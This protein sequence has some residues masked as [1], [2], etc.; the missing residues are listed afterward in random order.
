MGLFDSVMV[1]CPKCGVGQEA[2]SK[3]G[4]CLLGFFPLESAPA[5]VMEDVNRHAP[6]TCSACGTKF[7]VETVQRFTESLD[8][9]Y[10]T[11][12]VGTPPQP[13]RPPFSITGP[14]DR[15]LYFIDTEFDEDGKTINLLSIGITDDQ[16]R[17]FY[18]VSGEANHKRCN[19]W[20]K[21]NVLPHLG[22]S[23]PSPYLPDAP[24]HTREEIAAGI[25]KMLEDRFALDRKLPLFYGYFADYDWVVLCQLYGRMVDLPNLFGHFCM[26][27]K[28]IAVMMGVQKSEYPKQGTIEHNALNDA[29]WNWELFKFLKGFGA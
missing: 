15:A 25:I 7:K 1:P 12:P 8:G 2:Q 18:A 10:R 24:V 29:K 16:G 5:D 13:K 23:L 26:D 21:K 20:V 3:S 6:F 9:K 28:Q 19:D 17:D 27:L 14:K 11:E 4:P 22:Q